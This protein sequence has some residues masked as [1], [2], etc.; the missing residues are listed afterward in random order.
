MILWQSRLFV[1][2]FPDAI[3][4]IRSDDRDVGDAQDH[5]RFA[6][7]QPDGPRVKAIMNL[8]CL[9]T[10]ADRARQR[11]VG[12]WRDVD[13]ADSSQQVGVGIVGNDSDQQRCG[14]RDSEGVHGRAVCWPPGK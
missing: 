12:F 5:F 4:Q 9:A 1:N 14:Q 8:G 6:A 7:L 10:S 13:L 11:N 3:V 2:Q